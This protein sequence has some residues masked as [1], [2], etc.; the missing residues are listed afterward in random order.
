MVERQQ[1]HRAETTG[2]MESVSSPIHEMNNLAFLNKKDDADQV[3]DWL[4][5]GKIDVKHVSKAMPHTAQDLISGTIST[6]EIFEC[7]KRKM[8]ATIKICGKDGFKGTPICY[9]AHRLASKT[10]PHNWCRDKEQELWLKQAHQAFAHDLYA[11]CDSAEQMLADCK[12]VD[13]IP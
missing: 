9:L 1:Q 8:N 12:L 13:E 3:V 4:M 2:K 5:H 10:I 11:Q 7:L 6:G